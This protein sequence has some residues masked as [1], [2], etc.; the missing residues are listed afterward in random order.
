M[1][2]SDYHFHTRC[3]PDSAA[4]LAQQAKAA[5]AAGV[6]EICVTDHW[7]LLDQQGNRLPTVYDW[8]R[9]LDQWKRVRH[10]WPGELELRLGVEVGNGVLDPAAVDASLDLPEL[11]FVIGSLH[12]QSA[13]AGGRGIFTVAR[14][15]T[16]REEGIAL[17]DDYMDMLEELVQTDGYDVLGHVIYPLRYLPPEFQLDLHPWRDRLAE[18]F[19]TVIRRGKGIE[20]NTSAGTTVEQWRDVLTLYRDLGGEVLT[21][22]SDAHQSA[23]MAAAFP[24]AVELIAALGFRYLSVYRSRTPL[25]CKIDS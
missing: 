25:F 5:L 16:R 8:R 23:H 20:C 15:A 13:A 18:V 2:L 14:A 7:N 10:R 9:P 3:S 1:Y 12:S 19:R 22:G 11:D 21:L 17:L 4:P 6:R 24:Q